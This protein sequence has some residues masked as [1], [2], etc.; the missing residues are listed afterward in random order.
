MTERMSKWGCFGW[1]VAT[2]AIVNLLGCAGIPPFDAISYIMWAVFEAYVLPVIL[3]AWHLAI[4]WIVFLVERLRTASFSV[5]A[6]ATAI[7]SMVLLIFGLHRFL[8]RFGGQT[9]A[10][11]EGSIEPPLPPPSWPLHRTVAIGGLL[12]LVFGA[13]TAMIGLVHQLVWTFKDRDPVMRITSGR[14]PGRRLQSR[15]NMKQIGLATHYFLDAVEN[16]GALPPG[17]TF[18]DNASPLHGWM[19]HLLPFMD[20]APDYRRIDLTK[21]WT[22][23]ENAVVM[24]R[25]IHGYLNPGIRK[26]RVEDPPQFAAGHYSSNVWVVGGSQRRRLNEIRDGTAHT[27]LQGEI[28]D[29]IPAWGNPVNWRDPARG[30]NT[31]PTSFGS[32]FTGVCQFGLLDGSVRAISNDVDPDVLKALARPDDGHV[33]REY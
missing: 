7:L 6:I 32:P 26:T 31:G 20:R 11:L 19:T 8:G 17:A 29:N 14:D 10:A 1:I 9:P 33:P 23:P 16:K 12:I 4:G 21:P 15:N 30:I 27:I 28:V 25:E 5:E 18:D 13:G 3:I 2:L 22:D 24:R